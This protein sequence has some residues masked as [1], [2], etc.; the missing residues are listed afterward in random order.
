M[1]STDTNV[2]TWIVAC[3]GWLVAV[4]VAWLGYAERRA[5]QQADLLLKTVAHFEGG[6]QKRSIGIALVEG[7][8]GKRAEHKGVLVPLLT[9]QFVYLLLHPEVK[10]S[11][12]EERNLVRIFQLLAS[13]PA[14]VRDHHYS[15]CEAGDAIYRRLEGECSGL[16]VSEPTLKLWRKTLGHEK[17]VA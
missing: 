1:F 17:S 4:F 14:L 9:N 10:P 12:H 11:P 15:W 5:S 8:L 2:L 13:T 6:T 16:V 7:L 3:G